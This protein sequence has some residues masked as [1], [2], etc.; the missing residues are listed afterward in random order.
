MK[1]EFAAGLAVAISLHAL[2]LFGVRVGTSANPLAISEEPS[3]IQVTLLALPPAAAPA[4]VAPPVPARHG[5][6][7]T[8]D[9]PA[10]PAEPEPIPDPVAVPPLV[11]APAPERPAIATH[12]PRLNHSNP[13]APHSAQGAAANLGGAAAA[14]GATAAPPSARAGY[15]SNPMPDYPAEARRLRQQG[16]VIVSVEVGADGRPGEVAVSRGSGYPLLDAA[17]VEGVRRWT[18]DPARAAGVPVP[19]QVEVPV[20]FTLSQ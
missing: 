14:H 18:F 4:F 11:A 7:P 12:H 15:R 13:S 16:L 19:S 9:M 1:P 20:R 5:P 6:Q 17:A 3:P 8:P 10:P 2:L